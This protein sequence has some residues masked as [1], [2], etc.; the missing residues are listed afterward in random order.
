MGAVDDACVYPVFPGTCSRVNT[1]H[2]IPLIRQC[3][4]DAIYQGVRGLVFTPVTQGAPVG[5]RS[6]LLLT[7]SLTNERQSPSDFRR[8]EMPSK[9]NK[10]YLLEEDGIF[11]TGIDR[12]PKISATCRPLWSPLSRFRH[13]LWR[14]C[15][16]GRR[17]CGAPVASEGRSASFG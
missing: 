5:S 2:S 4:F 8:L 17:F 10:G 9:S 7:L 14:L 12:S 1:R 16:C 15:P 3:L 11:P 6:A 13:F